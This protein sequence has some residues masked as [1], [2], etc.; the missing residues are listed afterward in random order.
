MLPF[1]FTVEE[2]NFIAIYK[3][4]TLAATITN[5]AY[6]LPDIDAEMLIIADCAFRKLTA[7]TEPEFAALS[8]A[9]AD[10]TDEE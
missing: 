3:A 4:D 1:T 6:A 8:F 7:L 5:I 9:P 10:D 2:T